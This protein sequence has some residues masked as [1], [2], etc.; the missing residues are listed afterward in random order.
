MAFKRRRRFSR[1]RKRVFRRKRRTSGGLRMK[2][3]RIVNRMSE[4]KFFVGNFNVNI[5][6]TSAD[7]RFD[8]N[9]SVG[10]G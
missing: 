2:V 4:H 7:S 9:P 3:R 5:N 8:F 6:S 10:S 1:K